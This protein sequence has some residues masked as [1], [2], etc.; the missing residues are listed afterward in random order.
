MPILLVN[1]LRWAWS[2]K[3]LIAALLAVAFLFLVGYHQGAASV[4][5][6]W[7]AADKARIE[8][9]KKEQDAR[10]AAAN[11][12]EAINARTIARLNEKVTTLTRRLT[13]V[14]QDPAYRCTPTPDGL[15]SLNDILA[16]ASRAAAQRDD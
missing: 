11:K 9:Q 3:K 5:A 10:Q 14:T 16:A 8:A 6:D 12:G 13:D 2:N 4:Q 15:Q 1:L 7:D